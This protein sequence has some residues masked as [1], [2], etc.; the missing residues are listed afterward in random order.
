M[1]ELFSEDKKE[2]SFDKKR[3]KSTKLNTIIV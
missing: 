3:N 2:Q 1:I